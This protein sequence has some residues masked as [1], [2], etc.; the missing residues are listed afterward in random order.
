MTWYMKIDHA[1]DRKNKRHFEPPPQQPVPQQS[2][3]A[4]TP[5]PYFPAGGTVPLC[6]AHH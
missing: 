2:P 6:T 1:T 4:A 3:P 5:P